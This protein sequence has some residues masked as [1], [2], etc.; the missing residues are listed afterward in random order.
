M[1]GWLADPIVSCLFEGKT[2]GIKEVGSALEIGGGWVHYHLPS[3]SAL[4]HHIITFSLRY[5]G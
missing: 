4:Y 3:L 5:V 1:E 2:T